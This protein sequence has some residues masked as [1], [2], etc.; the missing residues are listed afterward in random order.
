MI[1]RKY[2][3]IHSSSQFRPLVSRLFDEFSLT[4][5]SSSFRPKRPLDRPKGPLERRRLAGRFGETAATERLELCAM[6]YLHDRSGP[7]SRSHCLLATF[8]PI[9]TTRDCNASRALY[10]HQLSSSESDPLLSYIGCIVVV[11]RALFRTCNRFADDERIMLVLRSDSNHRLAARG[12][13]HR[14]PLA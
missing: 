12:L 2:H 1:R 13:A 5:N 3:G 6:A 11:N 7:R 4:V 9:F 8:C 10:H 14:L